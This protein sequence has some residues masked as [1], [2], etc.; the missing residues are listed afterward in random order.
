MENGL[1]SG[2]IPP[3]RVA[4]LH[5][6]DL[7]VTP[8]NP[9]WYSPA[10]IGVWLFSIVAILLLPN[11]FVLPYIRAREIPFTDS[12]QLLKF[13]QNDPTAIFL[14][15]LAIIPAHILTLALAW[16][17]VTKLRRF[18]FRRTLGWSWGGM[19]WWHFPLIL[20]GFMSV[21]MIASNYILEQ[22]NDLLRIIRS[23]RTAVYLLAFLAT[24]TAPVVEEV[25][26]RGILYSAFQ[27]AVGVTSS[28]ILVTLLFALVHVPQYY[29]SFVTIALLTLL[30]LILTLVR[31]A[32]H[33][34]LP[35]IVLHFFF[36]AFQS[37]TLIL[38]PYMQQEPARVPDVGGLIWHFFK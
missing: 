8:D 37:L 13:L 29:P 17:V 16:L 22:E 35:C 18:D 21:A 11:L 32:T 10:A 15:L 23:S 27:R 24:V 26:Y 20:F 2:D 28:V 34:L 31:A 38:E 25:I 30:S 9:P 19:T 14:S 1:N 7:I 33:N 36:N 12:E 5:I 6:A 4:P 3:Q